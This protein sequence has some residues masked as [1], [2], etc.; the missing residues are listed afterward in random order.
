MHPGKFLKSRR[1][2]LEISQV[3]LASMLGEPQPKISRLECG[4]RADAE[5]TAKVAD[6]LGISPVFF[7]AIL[8]AKTKIK[9]K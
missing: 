9:T 7:F 3:E 5:L 6:V 4:A 1:I 2:E 8:T